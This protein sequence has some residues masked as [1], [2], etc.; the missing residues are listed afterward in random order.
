MKYAIAAAVAVIITVLL[1]TA[2]RETLVEKIFNEIENNQEYIHGKKLLK[3]RDMTDFEWDRM[4]VL[5]GQMYRE[6]I[7]KEIGTDYTGKV[8]WDSDLFLVVFIKGNQIVYDE[9]YNT[10][11]YSSRRIQF[12]T[13]INYTPESA[14]FKVEKASNTSKNPEY[15]YLLLEVGS[16]STER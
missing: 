9:I 11:E 7:S 6:Y 14:V 1:I 8:P 15:F 12:D 10:Y 4:R 13:S 16:D 5:Y 3:L 2:C